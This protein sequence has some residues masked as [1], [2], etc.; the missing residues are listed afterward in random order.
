MRRATR[1]AACDARQTR[2]HAATAMARIARRYS[3]TALAAIKMAAILL[4]RK[5]SLKGTGAA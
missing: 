2:A 3:G 1:S 4:E 5:L